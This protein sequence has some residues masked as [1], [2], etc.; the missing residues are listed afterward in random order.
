MLRKN[1]M[2]LSNALNIFLDQMMPKAF[3]TIRQRVRIKEMFQT[4]QRSLGLIF[5][6]NQVKHDQ[7]KGMFG[8]L[9]NACKKHLQIMLNP[10]V[11][12]NIQ[13]LFGTTLF[14]QKFGPFYVRKPLM[15]WTGGNH[16]KI[17]QIGKF[18]SILKTVSTADYVTVM[19]LQ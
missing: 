19:S 2:E 17:Y 8:L 18:R 15:F 13:S 3:W 16:S 6:P 10:V 9:K 11:V 4:K 1:W 5:L 7:F 14:F 12:S